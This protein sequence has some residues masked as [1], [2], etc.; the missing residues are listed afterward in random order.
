MITPVYRELN[1]VN[2]YLF[3]IN[4]LNR[5]VAQQYFEEYKAFYHPLTV[6]KINGIL[7]PT[8][9]KIEWIKKINI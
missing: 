1:I 5:V 7:N 4:Y 9:L 3:K 2:P 6:E 8:S